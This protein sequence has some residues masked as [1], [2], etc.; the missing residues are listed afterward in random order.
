MFTASFDHYLIHW[1]F[2]AMLERIEETAMMRREDILSRKV[3][4]YF[5]F[6]EEKLNKGR[7]KNA[8]DFFKGKKKK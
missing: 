5:R 6:I 8:R 1:D 3:E 7:K 4:V 2:P